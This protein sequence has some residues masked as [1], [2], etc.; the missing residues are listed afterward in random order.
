M[1]EMAAGVLALMINS[2][3]NVVGA[4]VAECSTASAKVEKE[5]V[6]K[7]TTKILEIDD[8]SFWNN[9]RQTSLIG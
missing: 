9:S 7:E 5:K 6:E 4:G 2:A 3:A 1:N 8:S